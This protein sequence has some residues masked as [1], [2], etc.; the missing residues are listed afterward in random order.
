MASTGDTSTDPSEPD[1][2]F[3]MADALAEA[4]AWSKAIH[5]LLLAAVLRLPD[6][7]GNAFPA[8]WT[9][10]ELLSRV[11][12]P[13]DPADDLAY[14]VRASETA[15]FAGRPASEADYAL[16]RERYRRFLTWAGAH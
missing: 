1:G 10:R 11:P 6:R 12:M 14:L 13:D 3:A 7:L 9:G 8:S 4:G 15:H 5:A 2:D 16:C